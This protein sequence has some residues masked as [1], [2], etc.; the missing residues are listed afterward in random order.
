MTL[1]EIALKIAHTFNRHR[2]FFFVEKIKE[3]IVNIR[4]LLIRRDSGKYATS[5]EF[6]QELGCIE[7]KLTSSTEC[8]EKKLACDVVRT[9]VKI[10]KPIRRR[11]GLLFTY[12]GTV[13][14]QNSFA[15]TDINMVEYQLMNR[16]TGHLP[17]YAYHNGYVYVFQPPSK[18]IDKIRINGVFA[19][20]RDL[21]GFDCGNGDCYSDDQEFPIAEDMIDTIER[22]VMEKH[23]MQQPTNDE[24][25]QIDEN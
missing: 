23:G 5:N 21:A 22:M 3:D 17:M 12:V 9:V 4:A 25:V 8:C 13:D 2:D 16:F 18:S 1:N 11:S 14:R 19:D 15:L 10:P 7:V 20:P 24:Q 6:I